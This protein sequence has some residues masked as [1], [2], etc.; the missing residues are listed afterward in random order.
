MTWRLTALVALLAAAP[1]LRAADPPPAPR[2]PRIAYVDI[3]RILG[4]YD[5]AGEFETLFKEQRQQAMR[6][7]QTFVDEVDRIKADIDKLPMGT[8]ERLALQKRHQDLLKEGGEYAQ[9]RMQELD[10]M[11]AANLRA[12]HDDM[13]AAVK[14][15]A[16][17][18]GFDLVLQEQHREMDGKTRAEV[19]SQVTG[20]VVLYA[21]DGYDLTDSVLARM[22]AAYA[23]S[24]KAD[25]AKRTAPAPQ[26]EEKRS[27]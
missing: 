26:S 7:N 24:K 2:A 1:L 15:I 12:V 3:V 6:R 10:A 14:A 22:N 13:T 8:P 18:E 11:V 16:L 17:Q 9:A 21:K 23:D 20:R 25:A 4:K 19:F 27:K 5:R